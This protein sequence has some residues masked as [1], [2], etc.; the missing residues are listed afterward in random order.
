MNRVLGF[1]FLAFSTIAL[2][3]TPQIKSGATVYIEPADGFETF[4]AAAMIEYKVPLVVVA[5]KEK[6]E[7]I[8][9]SNAQQTQQAGGGVLGSLM[10]GAPTTSTWSEVSASFS[11]IDPRSSQIVFA[12]S[13]S[14]ER[15]RQAAAQVCAWRLAKFMKKQKQPVQITGPNPSDTKPVS[16]PPVQ[17]SANIESSPS[18]QG[19]AKPTERVA[20]DDAETQFHLGTLYETGK[21]VPQDYAQAVLWYRKAAEQN[22]AIAQYRLGVLYAN[23]VGVPLDK[24]QSAEWFQKAAEQGYVYAQEMLGSDYLTGEGVQRDYSEAYFWFDIACASRA[25]E[26]VAGERA[27]QRDAAA[28]YLTPADLSREQER[29]RQWLADHPAG[30]Q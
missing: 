4:L 21:G 18:T 10:D 17:P 6:A 8:I 14:R 7:Y 27:T 24:A 5:D 20:T 19:I 9:R 26:V 13:A 16:A 30:P 11:V 25:R 28:V 2:S 29:A 1:V 22:L 23:G 3:Q 12:G 15:S